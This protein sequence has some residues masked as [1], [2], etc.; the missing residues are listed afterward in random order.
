MHS[1]SRYKKAIVAAL[2][3]SGLSS[4]A[5]EGQADQILSTLQGDLTMCAPKTKAA[6]AA[7]AQC[8]FTPMCEH[9]FSVYQNS[10]Q[11]QGQNAKI[12]PES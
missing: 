1:I 7:A 11:T 5:A 10:P 4:E 8:S 2:T 6:V 9:M 3:A 12:S